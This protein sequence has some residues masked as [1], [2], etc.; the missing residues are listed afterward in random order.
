MRSCWYASSSGALRLQARQA[1][2]RL[3]D[4]GITILTLERYRAALERFLG[5]ELLFHRGVSRTLEQLDE[6]LAQYV[7][8]LWE[9]GDGR[10]SASQTLA[11]VQHYLLRRRAF[12]Q[13]WALVRIWG[14]YELP[15]RT[16]PLPVGVLLALCGVA[17]AEQRPQFAAGL[18]AAFRGFLRTGELISLRF[19]HIALRGANVVL[20]LP[21]T[22]IG[23]R[24][25]Q[26]EV[27]TF[28]CALTA[29]LLQI[30]AWNRA[31]G[32]TVVGCG[33]TGF[34]N[35]WNHALSRLSLNSEVLRPYS[36]RRGGATWTLQ[37]T[38][39]VELVLFRGRW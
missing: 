35:W 14:S 7:E 27:V 29:R 28:E 3:R 34:R 36:L 18:M 24:R 5:W 39:S 31:P 19:G 2:G 23:A 9:N 6:H 26:Q 37:Q 38:A 21:M 22:K 4:L 1:R 32:D 15:Q 20:A 17:L 16:P 10:S 11:A 8:Y 13:A 33:I 30:A 12:P 25:G